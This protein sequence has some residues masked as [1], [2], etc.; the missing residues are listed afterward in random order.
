MCA[1]LQTG[2]AEKYEKGTKKGR[3]GHRWTGEA[4]EARA[5]APLHLSQP[6]HNV[7]TAGWNSDTRTVHRK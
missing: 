1:G 3:R 7:G 2:E 5:E 4:S 6:T